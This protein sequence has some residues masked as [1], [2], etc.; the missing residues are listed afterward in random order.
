MKARQLMRLCIPV[1]LALSARQVSANTLDLPFTQYANDVTLGMNVT[2]ESKDGNISAREP[3]IV[4]VDYKN[5]TEKPGMIAE[6]GLLTLQVFVMDS[7]GTVVAGTQR[8]D[9]GVDILSSPM[10]LEPCETKSKYLIVSALYQFRK[11][12][13]YSVRVRQ[14]DLTR[15]ARILAEAGK[16]FQ[17][18]PYDRKRLDARCEELR[19]L[20]K[21][22]EFMQ[23]GATHGQ[24]SEQTQR[25]EALRSQLWHIGIKAMYTV[26]DDVALP[27][28]DLMAREWSDSY[29]VR[30]MRSIG[31]P[32]A[33]KL[34]ESLT[35]RKDSVGEAAR[36]AL[37]MPE[38]GAV[39]WSMGGY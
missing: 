8:P 39:Y 11:P 14:L 37:L 15:E 36:K 12:G 26:R 10:T 9:M 27:Y 6:S 23:S 28:L 17:V 16:T 24:P 2:V 7:S 13:K 34:I 33:K 38:S 5:L 20:G 22:D 35:A 32:R 31:T 25:E 1:L 29:A 3:L 4:R 19:D 30:A 21:L 18:L